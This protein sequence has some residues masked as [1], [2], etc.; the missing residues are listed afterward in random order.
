M[1]I[2]VQISSFFLLGSDVLEDHT[3]SIFKVEVM[4]MDERDGSM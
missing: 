3:T 1:V 4:R 2:H